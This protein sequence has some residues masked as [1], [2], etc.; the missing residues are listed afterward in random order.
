MRD[1]FKMTV[2][3]EVTTAQALCLQE[4]FNYWN[5]LGKL[6]GTRTVGLVVD[7]DGPFHPN[8]K[9]TTEERLPVLSATERK[10]AIVHDN[11]NGDRIYDAD[12]MEGFSNQSDMPF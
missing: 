12:P 10:R 8:I 2:E 11:G 1:R 7:G 6:G 4:M 3:F 5:T 9:I